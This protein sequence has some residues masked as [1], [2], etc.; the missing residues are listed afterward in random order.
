[1]TRLE[2]RASS[3]TAAFWSPERKGQ[4]LIKA[5]SS[6]ASLEVTAVT[7]PDSAALEHSRSAKELPLTEVRG[8]EFE[9]CRGYWT[10]VD[11]PVEMYPGTLDQL[12]SSLLRNAFVSQNLSKF[13]CFNLDV[14]RS[15]MSMCHLPR[16]V[17]PHATDQRRG[18]SCNGTLSADQIT[19]INQIIDHLV[20]NGT[21]V[22]ATLHRSGHP[23]T[24]RTAHRPCQ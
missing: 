6:V 14:A 11:S 15:V 2:S 7:A 8:C 3:R 12:L 5:S 10:Y 19:F 21:M 16:G 22:P 23:S 13:R 9:S 4:R 17:T 24:A 20:H 18:D 1:L